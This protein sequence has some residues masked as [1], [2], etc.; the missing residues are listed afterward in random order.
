MLE[1]GCVLSSVSGLCMVV[2]IWFGSQLV[3]TFNFSEHTNSYSSILDAGSLRKL[4][5]TAKGYTKI[6]M[7]SSL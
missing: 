6:D 7:V 5:F 3:E 4:Y 1:L 2:M